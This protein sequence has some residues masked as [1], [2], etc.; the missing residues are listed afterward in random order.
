MN[1]GLVIN[2]LYTRILSAFILMSFQKVVKFD[3]L[4][5]VFISLKA[6]MTALHCVALRYDTIRCDAIGQ[7]SGPRTDTV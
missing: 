7:H 3:C 2:M 5:T 6:E 1:K 4:L